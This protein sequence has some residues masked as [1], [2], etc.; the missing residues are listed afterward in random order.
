MPTTSTTSIF[1]SGGK[2][3]IFSGFGNAANTSTNKAFGVQSF[4]TGWFSTCI[5]LYF[6]I[7]RRILHSGVKIWIYLS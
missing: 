4:G 6:Y 3:T 1:N 5:F 7:K 2:S